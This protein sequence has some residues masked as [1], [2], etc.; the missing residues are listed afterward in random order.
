MEIGLD[1]AHDVA[2]LV[3]LKFGLV[4]T[5]KCK[6][7]TSQLNVEMSHP[8]N[9]SVFVHNSSFGSLMSNPISQKLSVW[10]IRTIL[11]FGENG[12]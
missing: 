5:L 12:F 7:W 9:C 1:I 6:F 2:I 10:T 8:S 3:L 4:E 11:V